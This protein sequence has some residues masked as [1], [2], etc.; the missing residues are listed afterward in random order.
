VK[1]RVEWKGSLR[2]RKEKKEEIFSFLGADNARA[3]EKRTAYIF[4]S[5]KK[6]NI[7]SRPMKVNKGIRQ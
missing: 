5:I 4:R 7:S 6:G 3:E 2:M 1:G